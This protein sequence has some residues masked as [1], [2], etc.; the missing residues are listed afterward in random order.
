VGRASLPCPLCA[1][2][3]AYSSPPRAQRGAAEGEEGFPREKSRQELRHAQLRGLEGG[4]RRGR[5][6]VRSWRSASSRGGS[7]RSAPAATESGGA[8]QCRSRAHRKGSTGERAASAGHG[9][10]QH[11]AALAVLTFPAS[12]E[13]VEAP[14]CGRE[15][16]AAAAA[17]AGRSARGSAPSTRQGGAPTEAAARAIAGCGD[18]SCMQGRRVSTRCERCAASERPSGS[19]CRQSLTC[20]LSLLLV[21]A[22]A[23]LAAGHAPSR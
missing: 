20:L 15:E 12:C 11:L 7:W 2:T 6:C 5:V 23:P 17:G 8:G 13:R 9:D 18:A 14:R 16:A 3:S 19:H 21:P 1:S 22:R 4:G 10:G